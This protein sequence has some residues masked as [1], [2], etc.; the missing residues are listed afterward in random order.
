VARKVRIQYPGA[1][2]H[3][4]SR[5]N[6]GQAI[7]RDDRDRAVFLDTLSEGSEKTGWQV[8]AYVLLANHYHL[9]VETPEPNLVAGMKWL[10]GTYTQRFH[11]RHR[12]FGHL[13]QGRYKALLVDGSEDAYFQVVST[14]IHLNPARAGLVRV[15][16]VPLRTYAWSSYPAYLRRPSQRPPWLRVD[17]VFGSVGIH[18]DDTSGRRGYEA[19][20][21]GRVLELGRREGQEA[22][23]EEWSAIRRGWYLGEVGFRERLERLLE[24]TLAGKARESFSGEAREAHDE[25]AAAALLSRGLA[26]LELGEAE[27]AGL[28]KGAPVKQVLAWWLRQRTTVSRRWLSERLG[29]GDASRVTQAVAAVRQ[30]SDRTVLG[31][32][33]RLERPDS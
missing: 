7:F 1:V 26:A 27:L 28:A 15:G 30:A 4:M 24:G 23:N 10:Q 21:E 2:Y 8:H 25:A 20:L 29:M 9:L 19:Y 18:A 5:G 32:R 6:Q 14:Y 11:A 33:R 13:L 31:L 12:T 3:V 22:L 17:R 16:E